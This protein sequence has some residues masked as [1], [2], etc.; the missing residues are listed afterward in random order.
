MLAIFVVCSTNIPLPASPTPL[1]RLPVCLLIVSTVWQ[2]YAT[3]KGGQKV[4]AHGTRSGAFR[5]KSWAQ[6][7]VCFVFDVLT[8]CLFMLIELNFMHKKNGK[9]LFII[10]II[11]ETEVLKFCLR[12]CNNTKKSEIVFNTICHFN[13]NCCYYL[14]VY[15]INLQTYGAF[16]KRK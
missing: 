9:L 6:R 4:S 11:V 10:S 1:S 3:Q 12:V 15:S 5:G 16:G 13:N 2:H 8:A 14:N 7:K